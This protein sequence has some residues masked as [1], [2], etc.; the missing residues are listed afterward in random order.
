MIFSLAR[1]HLFSNRLLWLTGIFVVC[2]LTNYYP[3]F[4]E[5]ISK[6]TFHKDPMTSEPP[7]ST[8]PRGPAPPLPEKPPSVAERTRLLRSSFRKEDGEKPK[9]PDKPDKSSLAAS[10]ASRSLEAR[11]YS[12]GSSHDVSSADTSLTGSCHSL[13]SNG[14][15]GATPTPALVPPISQKPPLPDRS[16]VDKNKDCDNRVAESV[17]DPVCVYDLILMGR[18]CKFS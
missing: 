7:P 3:N 15:P 5:D 12:N 11:R 2:F 8:A 17:V 6:H 16:P 9:V 4:V 10:L 14:Q 18:I 13:T 1:A